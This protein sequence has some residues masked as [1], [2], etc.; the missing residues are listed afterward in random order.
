VTFARP[1]PF[2]TLPSADCL[3]DCKRGTAS[4]SQDFAEFYGMSL[5]KLG[6]FGERKRFG[7]SWAVCAGPHIAASLSKPQHEQNSVNGRSIRE[8]IKGKN[9]QKQEPIRSTAVGTPPGDTDATRLSMVLSQTSQSAPCGITPN[10]GRSIEGLGIFTASGPF[11]NPL[12]GLR[13]RAKR[14]QE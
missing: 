13:C 5:E 7:S 6:T 2:A 1:I 10:T 11:A 12:R 3:S 8:I 14:I 9:G 4:R